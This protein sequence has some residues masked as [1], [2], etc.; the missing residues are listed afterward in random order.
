MPA[1]TEP[2]IT[3]ALRTA[4]KTGKPAALTDGDG[5]GT[6]RLRLTIRPMPTRTLAEWYAVQWRDGKRTQAKL[7]SYPSMTLKEARERFARDYAGAIQ[8]GASIKLQAADKPGT[9]GDLFAGYLAHLEAAGKP[10][11]VE[12]RKGL[13]KAAEAI[14]RRRLAREV[15]PR[16]ITAVLAPIYARGSA[17]MADHVRSYLRAAFSWGLKADNDYR[18][19]NQRQR[20]NLERNPAADIP[21]EPKKVGT[22]W[23]DPAEFQEVYRWLQAPDSTVTPRYTVAVRLLM[24]TGQRVREITQLHADQWNS[25]E[26]LLTW[27]KTKNGRPHCIP[28]C[29]QAADLLDGLTPSPRGW[30]IPAAMDPTTPVTDEALYCMLWR[31]RQRMSLPVFALRDLRRTWKTLAGEAGLTKQERDLLQN[32]ARHDVSSRHYDR[33]EYMPEKRAAIDKWEIWVTELVNRR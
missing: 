21:T 23:L 13:D 25:A 17:S 11:A 31:T 9:V 29:K 30:L 8:A 22:R 3:R 12:V 4:T 24:L 1:L 15:T 14:G 32:H 18:R 20:F 27:E 16:E 33:Y 7:G 28:V 26:R 2:E 10:S 19:P 5:K 6:G